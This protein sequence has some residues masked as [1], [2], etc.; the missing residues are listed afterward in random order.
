[1]QGSHRTT[2]RFAQTFT[3]KPHSNYQGSIK[4]GEVLLNQ[5]ITTENVTSLF[6]AKDIIAKEIRC[7]NN[8]AVPFMLIKYHDWLVELVFSITG[9][10]LKTVVL[11]H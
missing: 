3:E 10:Q 2:F 5:W 1:M 7:I 6:D 4:I 9:N 11:R 8:H